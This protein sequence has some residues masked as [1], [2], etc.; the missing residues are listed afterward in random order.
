M[1]TLPPFFFSFVHKPKSL[2]E[3]V[4]SSSTIRVQVAGIGVY[5]EPLPLG[6]YIIMFNWILLGFHS[7]L[8]KN[9]IEKSRHRQFVFCFDISVS[10][11]LFRFC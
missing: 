10:T 8:R 6:L 7:V 4:G 1:Q 11:F 3:I 9:T 2:S 5:Q